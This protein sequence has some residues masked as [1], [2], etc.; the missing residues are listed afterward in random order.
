M[1]DADFIN[2]IDCFFGI[3]D[4]LPRTAIPIALIHLT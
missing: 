2:E 1:T 4:I 3:E